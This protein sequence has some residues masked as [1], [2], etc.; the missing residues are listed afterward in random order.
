MRVLVKVPNPPSPASADIS[1]VLFTSTVRN[2]FLLLASW[3]HGHAF[4][5][6]GSVPVPGHLSS[7]RIL[8]T[9]AAPTSTLR[10]HDMLR[11]GFHLFSFAS[12]VYCQV[13]DLFYCLDMVCILHK[14][15]CSITG[16]FE[17]VD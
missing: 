6:R 17:G 16:I 12:Q 4:G 13:R 7:L 3:I 15:N 5:K 8:R 10:S 11:G 14:I 1:P 9:G 2:H